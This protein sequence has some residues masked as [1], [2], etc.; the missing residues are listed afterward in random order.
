[1][2]FQRGANKKTKK[3]AEILEKKKARLF[4]TTR[5][6]GQNQTKNAVSTQRPFKNFFAQIL[7]NFILTLHF[8][9][10]SS[11][12]KRNVC[13]RV[14]ATATVS[15]STHWRRNA[16]AASFAAASLG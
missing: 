3:I 7:L 4:K 12:S 16:F 13:A 14:R 15:P 6:D 8:T 10:A 11:V 5:R 1:M 9:A 2:R